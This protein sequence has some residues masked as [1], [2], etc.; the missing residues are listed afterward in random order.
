M[1]NS[2][3]KPTPPSPEAAAVTQAETN[4]ASA[5]LAASKAAEEPARLVTEAAGVLAQAKAA[6]QVADEAEARRPAQERQAQAL[7]R[8]A[9]ID[10][11]LLA[12]LEWIAVACK[13]RN[14]LGTVSYSASRT[15]GRFNQLLDPDVKPHSVTIKPGRADIAVSW[16]WKN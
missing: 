16:K 15:L 6:L 14:E 7:A 2:K 11:A 8:V 9:E 3:T 5:Q 4:L 13:E 10:S 1:F 12:A